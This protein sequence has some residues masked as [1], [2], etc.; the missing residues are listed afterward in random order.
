MQQYASEESIKSEE[1]RWD[2]FMVKAW[3]GEP[4]SLLFRAYKLH[5]GKPKVS[6][7]NQCAEH[8]LKLKKLS[9]GTSQGERA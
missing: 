6:K 2:L 4:E 5:S 3:S 7:P 8:T 9:T 1:D